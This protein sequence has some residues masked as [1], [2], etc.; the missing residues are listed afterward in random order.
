MEYKISV[1]TEDY[2]NADNTGNPWNCPLF[3]AIKRDGRINASIVGINRIGVYNSTTL[4]IS[5][6]SEDVKVDD[7]NNWEN[8]VNEQI[9]QAKQGIE[10]PTV[11]VT[12]TS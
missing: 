4:S 8:N 9:K 1:T 7:D 2:K 6:W 11:I 5:N 3:H 12:L 10:Q